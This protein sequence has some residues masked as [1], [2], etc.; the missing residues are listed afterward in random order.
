MSNERR[1]ELEN[2]ELAILLD[3]IS[4][5]IEPYSKMIAVAVVALSVGFVGWLFYK[6]QQTG[7]RSDATLELVQA[8]ASQ[9]PEVLLE[10]SSKYP[11]TAA[12]AWA[13]VYQGNL[14]LSTGIQTLYRDR[15]Q[16]L[17]QLNE[18]KSALEAALAASA[19]PLLRS[20]AQLGI[21]RAEESLGNFEAAVAAYEQV[22]AIGESEAVVKQARQRIAA[23]DDPETKQF[24]T[25]FDDQDF[26]P[27]DPS[28]PPSLPGV[29]SLPD[30]PDFSL[31][32]LPGGDG[33]IGQSDGL[34][35]F[36]PEGEGEEA[37]GEAPKADPKQPEN[38]DSE[39]SE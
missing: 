33:K 7:L 31:T 21:A 35:L 20:R 27:A 12:A 39:G 18:A 11:G 6:S 2:N 19:D 9:D 28:L 5:G 14:E 37:E 13:Q 24:L 30:I 22:A 36:D 38:K 8:V 4:K 3:R 1:H 25:W 29:D 23:L 34:E 32:E 10:V 15:E 26:A 17:D 16:A